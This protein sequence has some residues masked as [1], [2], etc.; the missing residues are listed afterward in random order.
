MAV[1]GG[2]VDRA[3]IAADLGR[4][5]V[6]CH[7]LLACSTSCSA[8]WLSNACC[9]LVRL[10]GRLPDRASQA[11]ARVLNATTKPF[12]L[13][14]YYGSCAAALVYNRRRMGAKLD[15]VVLALR[16]EL[17]ANTSTSMPANLPSTPDFRSVS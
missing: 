13:V 15:R 3:A 2:R 11:Y 14:N 16:H 12:H 7:R 1:N 17:G 10:F 6:E 9:N 5:R 8:T 4:A